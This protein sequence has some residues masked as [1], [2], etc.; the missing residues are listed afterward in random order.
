MVNRGS[1]SSRVSEK[2]VGLILNKKE[3]RMSH[4]S[5]KNLITQ[6]GEVFSSLKAFGQSKYEI[7][8]LAAD[9]Y[10]S[11]PE[12]IRTGTKQKYINTAIRDKIFSI[13]TH[14]S[15]WKHTLYFLKWCEDA[16][17]CRT[18]RECR[19]HADEWLLFRIS[20]G[21]SAYTIALERAALG[22]LYK[23]PSTNFIDIPERKRA[24][25]KRSRND[26]VRDR[27]FSL[28]K[29]ADLISFSR[30]TGLRRSELQALRGTDLVET[31]KGPYLRIK[32]KGGRVRLS[33]IIGPDKEA[34]VARMKSSGDER[35]WSRVPS[36]MDVHQYRSEYATAI[37]KS[38]ARPLEVVQ[39]DTFFN[40]NRGRVESCVY[41][42]RGDRAG[43]WFDKKAMLLAS[44]ALGHNRISV[45]GEHYIR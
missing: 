22:K 38:N 9:E 6:A 31:E 5:K 29:N 42:C 12:T 7:K 44:E 39:K 11:I 37:Y 34:I 45:V 24:D 41:H 23:E 40:A 2:R 8:R 21:H 1:I 28:A 15:Y 36:H 16:Y 14:N 32:G 3:V 26:V 25:I 27:G 33:P 20:Q 43:E 4:K 18:L 17:A 30:G 35:V 19:S 13:S 10:D